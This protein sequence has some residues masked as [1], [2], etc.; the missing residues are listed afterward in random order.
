M[1]MEGLGVVDLLL[2]DLWIDAWS[3]IWFRSSQII[4]H[5]LVLH[6]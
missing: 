2:L 3:S 5:Q 4:N 1:A 6:S